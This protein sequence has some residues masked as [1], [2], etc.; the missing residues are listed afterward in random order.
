MFSHLAAAGRQ[1][2][3]DQMRMLGVGL[4]GAALTCALASSGWTTESMP[5]RPVL[6]RRG[7]QTMEPFVEANRLARGE[8]DA[9]AWRQRC[10]DLGIRDLAL[11]SG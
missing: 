5:G 3:P 7:D 10:S 1:L 9:E 6:M 8:L 2:A 4:A 11:I